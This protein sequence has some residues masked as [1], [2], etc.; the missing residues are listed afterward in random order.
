VKELQ[1]KYAVYGYPSD[2]YYHWE[3]QELLRI[4]ESNSL[5]LKETNLQNDDLRGLTFPMLTLKGL[6]L[7][8]WL[9]TCLK[10]KLG[11]TIM[12]EIT[13]FN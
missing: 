1:T 6:T 4:G 13:H 2:S 10:I 7:G 5:N 3:M 9:R 8:G 12:I 11:S